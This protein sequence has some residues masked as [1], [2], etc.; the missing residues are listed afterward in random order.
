MPS[1]RELEAQLLLHQVQCA[2]SLGPYVE[3]VPPLFA[4]GGA[5]FALRLVRCVAGRPH[6]LFDALQWLASLLAHRR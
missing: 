2:I 5:K 1:R 6:A 3:F 4:A